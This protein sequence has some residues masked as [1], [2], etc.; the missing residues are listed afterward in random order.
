MSNYSDRSLLSVLWAKTAGLFLLLLNGM[1]PTENY[2]EWGWGVILIMSSFIFPAGWWVVR[3]FWLGGAGK[4]AVS[5]VGVILPWLV[6]F[7]VYEAQIKCSIDAAFDFLP[8][9]EREDERRVLEM[10]PAPI[11]PPPRSSH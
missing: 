9:V 8:A 1:I 4:G 3:T 10:L 2:Q 11:L 6:T 7:T 5:V